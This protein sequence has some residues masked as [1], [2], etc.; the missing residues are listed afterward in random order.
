MLRNYILIA[1]RNLRKHKV[2]A[3]INIAGLSLGMTCCLLLFLLIRH[4]WSFDRFHEDADNIYRTTIAYQAPD[5][6]THYQNM[7]F[8]DFTPQLEAEFPVI[9]KATRFVQSELD[10]EVGNEL[11]R[12]GLAEVDAPFFEMFSFPLLAGDQATVLVDPASMVITTEIADSWF[13]AH[14]ESYENAI[15]Q[16]VS[17]TRDEVT[18][19]FTI[20]GVAEVPPS[21]SSLDFEVVIPF[22]NYDT[23]QL[24]GNNWGGRTSTYILL[25]PRTSPDDLEVALRPFIDLQ[26]ADYQDGLRSNGFLVEGDGVFNMHL[27]PLREVHR[28]PD[29]W[30]PYEVQ[31]NDPVYSYILAVI[32]FLILIIA[33][34][35]FTTLTIGR[36]STRQ[37]EVG[38]RKVLGAHRRQLLNQFW[39][40][41]VM[42]TAVSMT[43]ATLLSW[44][45]LPW[46]NV[47]TN[48][49]LAISMVPPLEFGGT[50]VALLFVVGFVAGCYPAAVL[51]RFEPASVLKGNVPGSR[52]GLTRGLV[53]LQYTISIGLTIAT[54]IMAS[55]LTYMME[56]D[57]GYDKDLVMIVNARQVEDSEANEVIERF[58]SRLIPDE[59]ITHLARSGQTF[60]RGTDRNTWNDENGITRQAY[61]FGVGFD[62]VEL[63]GMEIVAGRNFSRDYPSDSSHS[64]LVNEALVRQFEIEDP[65]GKPLAN[66]LSF[67]YDESPIVIGVVK[68]FHFRSLHEEVEP[69]VLN[70]HPNYYNYLEALLVRMAPG[71]MTGTIATVEAAWNEILPGKPFT[72]TFLDEDLALAYQND[73]R[74][75]S[76]VQYSAVLA[77]LIACLGMLGLATISVSRRTKEIGV[78]KVLGATVTGVLRLVA[79]E[80][81]WLIGIA[82]VIAF[83]LAYYGMNEW[84]AGFA[85]RIEIGPGVFL[86]A[87]AMALIIAMLSI[88]YHAIRAA[89]SDPVKA[90]RYE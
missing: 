38:M 4:E 63:M 69:A 12:N 14:G 58:R 59:R 30:V 18:Y 25:D 43:F 24:G 27:Q 41:A 37:R 47:V 90:L 85:S 9:E 39:G 88:S 67:I 73:Q 87:T 42:L 48:K 22:E 65:V 6:S 17:I 31:P 51:S 72:Y 35:N 77:I 13:G 46:F 64:V 56:K 54:L 8:P 75:T 11:F 84:L 86:L 68:D 34:I 20:T 21:N 62:Y 15:G 60:N 16:L 2:H 28:Q 70:M 44:M 53:V 61:N 1:F 57:L 66:W 55:Q 40:E 82:S 5:G 78:R 83:P 26:F 49:E 29:V 36:S 7:M 3:F 23:I 76:I 52:Q 89:T 74:W 10:F 32:G 50:L 81:A 33:C 19:D 71:D 79:S 45:V 80:F